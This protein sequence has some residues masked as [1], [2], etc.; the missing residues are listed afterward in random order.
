M[1]V[2][3]IVMIERDILRKICERLLKYDA[4]IVEII[5]FGSSVYAPE[6][7]R[8]IDLL[9]LTRKAKDYSGYLDAV[10]LDDLP[11]NVDVIVVELDRELRED[12][13]R[14]VLGSFRVIYGS[15]K[16]ILDYA[17]TLSDPTFDEARAALRAAKDYMEL[18]KRTFDE[19]LKDRHIRE[20]FNTLFHAARIASMTYLSIDVSRWG[21]IRKMLPEPYREKFRKFINILHIEYFYHGNYPKDR[22]E[23]EFNY[24]F[25]E[26][27]DFVDK[28][29]EKT[30]KKKTSE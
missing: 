13:I 1:L 25:K 20:A 12:F 22:V 16:Y 3:A 7:A 30:T 19:L 9:V 2:G 26:V 11:F 17:K 28:L 18:A 6:C 14:G 5:Q 23:Q 21:I 24:W 15:G 29:E 4:N 27:S 8:D 10:S